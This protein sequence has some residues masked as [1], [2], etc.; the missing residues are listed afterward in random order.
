MGLWHFL[1]GDRLGD[2]LV[3]I[4]VMDLPSLSGTSDPHRKG[5]FPFQKKAVKGLGRRGLWLE[6]RCCQLPVG[7]F[8]FRLSKAHHVESGPYLG[9]HRGARAEG[10][11][12]A[13][14]GQSAF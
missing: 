2:S 13:L 1:N 4:V 8:T 7:H 9:K 11:V 12:P 6:I 3:M 14:R 5:W 10:S